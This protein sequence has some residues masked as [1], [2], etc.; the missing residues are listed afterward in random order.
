MTLGWTWGPNCRLLLLLSSVWVVF[1]RQSVGS[2]L[3]GPLRLAS[4]VK[5]EV[6][7]S[8]FFAASSRRS[9]AMLVSLL[10]A[11]FLW[12]LTVPLP[13]T[14]PSVQ[15]VVSHGQ[16]RA[17]AAGVRFV[18]PSCHSS[19]QGH[20]KRRRVSSE[21]ALGL[22]NQCIYGRMD[23]WPVRRVW[24]PGETFPSAISGVSGTDWPPHASIHELPSARTDAE[25]HRPDGSGSSNWR[26]GESTHPPFTPCTL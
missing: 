8:V 18:F 13:R 23:G 2:P 4:P 11:G 22:T 10:R 12:A 15:R 26:R 5:D 21:S 16:G 20:P 6:N 19:M 7:A 25:A 1:H 24:L 17:L 9:P 3:T 14:F